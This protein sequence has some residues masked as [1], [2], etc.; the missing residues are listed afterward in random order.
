MKPGTV[1]SVGLVVVTAVA[2]ILYAAVDAPH[3]REA[4]LG[5]VAAIAIQAPLGWIVVRY[6]GTDRLMPIWGAGMLAR[7]LA[8]ATLGFAGVP[9]TLLVAFVGALFALLLVEAGAAWLRHS[10]GHSPGTV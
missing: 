8:L 5:V 2:A 4:A 6:V 7:L 10:L 3:G 1:Y 9:A